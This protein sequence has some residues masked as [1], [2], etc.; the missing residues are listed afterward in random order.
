[1]DEHTRKRL[2]RWLRR[3]GFD[4]TRSCKDGTVRVRCSQCQAL[5]INGTACHERGCPG[6]RR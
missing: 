4:L 1:M 3:R 5:C 2:A 6:A